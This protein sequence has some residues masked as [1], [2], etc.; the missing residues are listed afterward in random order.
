MNDSGLGNL[1]LSRRG[2]LLT[3]GL[4]GGLAGSLVAGPGLAADGAAE[5]AQTPL[6]AAN[7]AL[8]TQFCL[9]WASR[10]IEKLMPYLADNLV[11]QMFEKR[12]DIIGLAEFRQEVGPFLQRPCAGGMGDPADVRHRPARDQ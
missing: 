10:D 12:P 9:D 2:L 1:L 6:E 7:A 11:Y 3:G 4:A 8:V 5:S